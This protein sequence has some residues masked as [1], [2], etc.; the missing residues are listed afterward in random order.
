MFIYVDPC[1]PN[2]CMNGAECEVDWIPFASK[3][4]CARGYSGRYCESGKPCFIY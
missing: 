1:N 4:Q 2:P 3:C